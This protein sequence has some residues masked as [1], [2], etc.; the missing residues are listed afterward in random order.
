MQNLVSGVQLHP[1]IGLDLIGQLDDSSSSDSESDSET[2][3]DDSDADKVD[4]NGA[5]EG[6]SQ[7]VTRYKC[8][9]YSCVCVCVCVCACVY[10]CAHAD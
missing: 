2:D 7:L 3:S 8:M 9:L 6:N 1:S 10:V 5:K 4:G